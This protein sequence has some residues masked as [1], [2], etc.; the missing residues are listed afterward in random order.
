GAGE[1]RLVGD[2]D[3][4]ELP[5]ARVAGDVDL[6]VAHLDLRGGRVRAERQL[7]LDGRAVGVRD[8][9]H[10]AEVAGGGDRGDAVQARG[11]GRVGAGVREVEHAVIRAEVH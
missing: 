2:V 9:E 8:V 1:D 7:V 4:D 6:H 11:G 10:G 3:H 5:V